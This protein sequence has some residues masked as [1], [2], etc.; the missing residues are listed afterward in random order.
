MT[1][2]FG[3][4]QTPDPLMFV[5]A[6]RGKLTKHTNKPN[7]QCVIVNRGCCNKGKYKKENMFVT[8]LRKERPNIVGPISLFVAHKLI[9][10]DTRTLTAHIIILQAHTCLFPKYQVRAINLGIKSKMFHIKVRYL[11]MSQL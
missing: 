2:L 1:V 5:P 7:K 8:M 9:V 4:I 6:D 3:S 10:K 11:M